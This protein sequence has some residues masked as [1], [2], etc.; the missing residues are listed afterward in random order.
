MMSRH[1][2]FGIGGPVD[3]WAEPETMNDLLVLLSLCSER[4][5]PYRVLGRGSNV[6]VRDGG[7]RGVVIDLSQA[8]GGLERTDK[9]IAA[10]AGVSLIALVKFALH[11]RLQGLE[12]CAGIPG[13]VGGAIA[14]NAGAW[15]ASI[16]DL[17]DTVLVFSVKEKKRKRLEKKEIEYGYRRSNLAAFGIILEAGFSLDEGEPSL[18]AERM[19][20]YIS[21][22]TKRQPLKVRSAGSIF[23]NPPGKFAGAIIEQ[24]GFKGC[25]RGNAAVSDIHANFI[26]NLGQATAVDVLALMTEIKTRAREKLAV[27]LEPEIE[28]IGEG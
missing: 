25:R 9:G 19:E 6:L 14:V 5:I 24:L 11:H 2:S 26:V 22:R 28:V 21:R 7:I 17:L 27:E 3:I 4:N 13:S 10:G 12:F 1:T 16:C 15:G 18:I 20:E 23:K 8:C